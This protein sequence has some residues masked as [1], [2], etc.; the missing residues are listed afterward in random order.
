MYRFSWKFKHL[1]VIGIITHHKYII[2]R[3]Q[4][5]F[6]LPFIFNYQSKYSGSILNQIYNIINFRKK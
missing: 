1:T 5:L 4:Q 3:F 6:I 2:T